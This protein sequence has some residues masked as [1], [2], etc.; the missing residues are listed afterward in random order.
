[1]KLYCRGRYRN[2]PMQLA[3]DGPG[4]ID[5]DEW[6]ARFLLKDAPENFTMELSVPVMNKSIDEPPE[7]TAMKRA[8]RKKAA[9]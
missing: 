7:D 5:I 2:P 1:M 8:P 6:K 9:E 3:F 4:V